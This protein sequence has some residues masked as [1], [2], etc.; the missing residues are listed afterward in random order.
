MAM[1]SK[2]AAVAASLALAVTP[3]AALAAKAHHRSAKSTCA[4][5]KKR[6]GTKRFDAR[7]GKG[8]KHAN[9]MTRCV[10]AHS[11]KKSSTSTH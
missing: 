9:A 10:R 3:S 5:L 11:S 4:A 1:P 7:Y 2:V 6:E 8:A